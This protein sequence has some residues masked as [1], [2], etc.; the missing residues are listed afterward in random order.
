MSSRSAP[1]RTVRIGLTGPIGCGKSTVA[2]RLEDLGAVV[3]DADQ[4]AREVT[5]PGTPGHD[6]ILERFGGTVTGDSGVLDRAALAR[7]VFVDPA[8]LHDLEGIVHPLVRPAIE[9][10]IRWAEEHRAPGVVVEA[11]RLVEGGLAAVCDVVVLVTCRREDQLARLAARGVDP[12]DAGRRIAAQAGLVERVRSSVEPIVIDTTGPEER[13]VRLVEE[14]WEQLL[15]AR[16][17]SEG[18]R[19]DHR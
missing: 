4:V 3:I 10:H 13:T 9:A 15:A 6:A 5:A 11:I 12:D 8:A 1:V 14:L 2:R 16:G 17:P 7:I 18:M 19:Q